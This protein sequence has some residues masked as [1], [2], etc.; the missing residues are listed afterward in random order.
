MAFRVCPWVAV[1]LMVGS[2]VLVGAAG[3]ELA[4]VAVWL[5]V[6]EAEPPALVPVTTARTVSPTSLAVRV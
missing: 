4:T 6:A 1:P 2:A 3:A 5:A